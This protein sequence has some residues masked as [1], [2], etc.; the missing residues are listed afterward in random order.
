LIGQIPDHEPFQNQGHFE[1][2]S[3]AKELGAKAT[4]K[5]Q[6]GSLKGG[7]MKNLFQAL[8]KYNESVNQS[9]MEL[10]KPLKK[11][12]VMMETKAYYPSIFATLLHN[13]IADLNWLRR[14]RDALKENKALNNGKLLSF[15]EKSLRL[16]FESDHTKFF[17]YR[18]QV[19]ELMIQFVNELDESKM[20]LVI[21]YKSYKGEEIEK[22][23]W[24]TLLHLFNHQT[25][26]RGQVSVLLDLIGIDHDYSS[27]VSRI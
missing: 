15:E 3:E 7:D 8:A 19:D 10:L 4:V 11:E 26:H 12:Q 18:K 9:I 21:K 2:V 6:S 20:H 24:K 13:L 23:L 27:L 17:P 14:Y 22:E 25:H 5:S 1:T 16:E